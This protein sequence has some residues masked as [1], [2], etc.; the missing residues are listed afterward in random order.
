VIV[1]G[2]SLLRSSIHS[3]AYVVTLIQHEL[4]EVASSDTALEKREHSLLQKC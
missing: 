3:I 1:L 4:V 2:I